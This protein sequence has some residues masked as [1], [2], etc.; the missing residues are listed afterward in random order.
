MSQN[1]LCAKKNAVKELL[2]LM[3]S[4]SDKKHSFCVAF[5]FP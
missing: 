2:L 1:N 4:K 5:F 3:K